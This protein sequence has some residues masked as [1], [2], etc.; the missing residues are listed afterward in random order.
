VKL[1][2]KKKDP[3]QDE[4]VEVPMQPVKFEQLK[5]RCAP[6][7]KKA[8]TDEL[9]ANTGAKAVKLK[10]QKRK[11]AVADVGAQDELVSV[12]PLKVETVGAAKKKKKSVGT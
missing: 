2:R 1:K 10:T 6:R 8:R 4:L 9:A 11:T 3:P 5:T 12:P 7:S